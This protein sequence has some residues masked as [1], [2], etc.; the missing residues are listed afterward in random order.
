MKS[1]LTNEKLFSM[2]YNHYSYAVILCQILCWRLMDC[3]WKYWTC[4]QM[5]LLL[6]LIPFQLDLC[7][8]LLDCLP[9]YWTR[10][11]IPLLLK[12]IPF[13]PVLWLLSFS[14]GSEN[15]FVISFSFW[16]QLIFGFGPVL[17]L[18]SFSWRPEH[19]LFVS[20]PFQPE[21]VLLLLPPDLLFLCF[22]F[23]HHVV[24]LNTSPCIYCFLLLLMFS[25]SS[26]NMHRKHHQLLVPKHVPSVISLG[27]ITHS[28][29]L[30]FR[31]NW[32]PQHWNYPYNSSVVFQI[33]YHWVQNL[34]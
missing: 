23:W 15:A 4:L 32:M 33:S 7:G 11:H 19:A 13:G 18:L 27:W 28:C 20:F 34:L 31:T 29:L 1:C 26:K 25:C 8:C 5:N 2:T 16:D 10:L 14:W 12:L 30:H 6:K 17:W 24:V 9:K 21:H 3:I 22:Y